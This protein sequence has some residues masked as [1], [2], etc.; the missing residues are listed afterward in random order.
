MGASA[1]AFAALLAALWL[2]LAPVA[3]AQDEG[4]F[5]VRYGSDNIPV[6]LVAQG[7]PQQGKEWLLALRFQPIAEKWHGYWRNPGDAGRGMQLEW[8]LPEGWESG[9]PLY[10]VPRQLIIAGL[11]N[12]IYEGDYAVL[13]PVRVPENAAVANVAPI[14]LHVE[15]LACTDEICV[16]QDAVLTLDPNRPTTDTNFAKWQA[17]IAP[18]LDQNGGFEINGNRLRIGISLPAAAELGQPHVYLGEQDLGDGLQP[19]YT[20]VQTFIR[21]GDLLVAELPLRKTPIPAGFE[22]PARPTQVTG[23][24][25]LGDGRGLRFV[26]DPADVPLEGV[27]PLSGPET[28]PLAV[29]L[30]AALLGGLLLNILPCVFPILSLK[31][32]ALA[33]AGGKEPAA[34]SDALAYT[35]GVVLAC[36]GLG[37]ALL[38]LRSAG[39]QVGWAFQ[40]QQPLVV[41]ALFLLAVL[42][43]ANF[44]NLYQLP[45][46]AISGGNSSRG[47]SFATGLLAAFV[48]TPCTGPFMAAALGAALVIPP[49]DGLLVFV[50]LG[51]GLALPFLLIGFVPALRRRLPK[52]GP[53]ME[54]FRRWMALPM[55]LTALAL[56]WLV[57]RVGGMTFLM[58]LVAI[59]T[60]VIVIVALLGRKQVGGAAAAWPWLGGALIASAIGLALLPR[61]Q[62]PT[63]SVASLHDPVAYSPATLAEARA[64]GQPVFLWFTADWCVTCKVNEQVAIER[65][66]VREAFEQAGVVVIRGDWTQP[67]EAIASFI[68][69][70]GAAGVPL[71]VWYAPGNDGQQLPQVLTQSMLVDLA[72]EQGDGT[73]R[74][75]HAAA[76]TD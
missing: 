35:A 31:A 66:T 67:D 39:A 18:A 32:L 11:M 72:Q 29:L 59:A 3:K 50:A 75:G 65:E 28:P 55:G 37:A 38:L 60:V 45:G 23:I 48:A 63:A 51:L 26:A 49:L 69:R 16:P 7:A 42:I 56:A 36:A 27:K 41:A 4:G 9:E 47:G 22:P 40:L 24:I 53:W 6:E 57:W 61:P 13:V 12:H 17:A 76:A 19:A 73:A 70:Q 64:S 14:S 8:R 71:Y 43:T 74:Q 5:E 68:T 34:R 1:R 44:L 62:S 21:E 30:L 25:E 33:K 20:E 15:Y 52:P 54:T 46:M 58:T 2:L 10:P